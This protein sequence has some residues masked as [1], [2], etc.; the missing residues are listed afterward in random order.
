ML[1]NIVTL[2]FKLI[3]PWVLWAGGVMEGGG[4]AMASILLEVGVLYAPAGGGAL[5]LFFLTTV[6]M[7]GHKL[8][9]RLVRR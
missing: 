6:M 7:A 1:G 5:V 3:V 4:N 8:V 9:R 2:L